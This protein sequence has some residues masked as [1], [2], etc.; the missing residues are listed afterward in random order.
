[1]EEG[2]FSSNTSIWT[3]KDSSG[4]IIA[5]VMAPS[6]FNA[7]YALNLDQKRRYQAH[8]IDLATSAE[9]ADCAARIA[10]QEPGFIQ[11]GPGI[12]W[13]KEKPD[14]PDLKA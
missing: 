9:K 2:V 11:P 4:A 7:R 3:V 1:M 12:R 10:R 5:Y 6:R 13:I 14:P 8:T